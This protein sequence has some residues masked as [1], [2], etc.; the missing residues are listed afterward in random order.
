MSFS[1]SSTASAPSSPTTPITRIPTIPKPKADTPTTTDSASPTTSFAASLYTS[2][3][4]SR[5]LSWI[6]RFT[7]VKPDYAVQRD[8]AWAAEMDR[9]LALVDADTRA[10][11]ESN[12][13]CGPKY[14]F[15][16]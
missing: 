11:S 9:L 13:S 4:P 7:R 16:R 5:R 3:P 14:S 6:E 15:R 1:S 2:Q 12:T 10:E 8:C